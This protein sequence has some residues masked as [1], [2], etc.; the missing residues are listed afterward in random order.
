MATKYL[1]QTSVPLQIVVESEKKTSVKQAQR[2]ISEFVEKV[3]GLST[4]MTHQMKEFE[5]FVRWTRENKLVR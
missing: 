4:D 2:T 3:E 5:K 1:A